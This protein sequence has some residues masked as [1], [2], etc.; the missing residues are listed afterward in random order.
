MRRCTGGLICPAQVKERLKHFVARGAF[1]IDG[2]GDKQ[3]DLFFEE[4]LIRQPADIFKLAARDAAASE[5]LADQKGFGARS[6]ENLFQAIERRRRIALDRFLYALGIRH[7]GEGTARDLA[8][9]YGSYE[10]FSQS[11]ERAIAGRPGEDYRRILA[12]PG[13][14]E[15]TAQKAI[16]AIAAKADDIRQLSRGGAA[17]E[18]VL[19]QLKV[20]PVRGARA[21]AAAFA[22]AD[23]LI[24]I[25]VRAATQ[26]PSDAYQEIAALDGIG[27]TVTEALVEFYSEPH[28]RSALNDLLSEVQVEPFKQTAAA[29]SPVTG[30]TVVFTGTLQK[31]T[32]SEAKAQAERL[33]AKVSGSVSKKTDY[34]IAGADAG[35][36]L[37]K[38]QAL[39]VA[40][41]SEDDW[42]AMIG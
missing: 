34:V 2:L 15:K 31:M 7:V 27:E 29:Q 24:E 23:Q 25:A 9:A 8:R 30:K 36:K 22:D 11:I 13:L 14:G 40:V 20:A 41:L 5:K 16:H 39:G 3:I 42:L 35:S 28:N 33:G 4:G 1:D 19:K 17:L 18:D 6:V 21:L 37:T 12:I 32:R 38:A 10:R 26:F